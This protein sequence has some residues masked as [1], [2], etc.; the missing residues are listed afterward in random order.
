[1][2]SMRQ[3]PESIGSNVHTQGYSHR[4]NGQFTL[5]AVLTGLFIGFVACSSNVYF[6]LQT[7]YAV[8]VAMP[9][10]LIGFGLSKLRGSPSQ[11]PLSVA[12]NVLISTIA[13]AMSFMPVTGSFVGVIP[14]LEH[15]VTEEE[16]GPVK[17][18][19]LQLL[20]WA[21]GLILFGLVS[22]LPLREYFIV[23][24]RLPFPSATATAILIST[25]HQK[26]ESVNEPSGLGEDN[27]TN[28][29]LEPSESSSILNPTIIPEIS[30]E[31]KNWRTMLN[32]LWVAACGSGLCV[33]TIDHTA[34][35]STNSKL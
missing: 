24:Q 17:L 22:I 31:E 11:H 21:L 15:L 4:N 16:N 7:G 19:T 35:D 32:A 27:D 9:A 10:S 3:Q 6:G 23:Y 18:K 1:V 5:R 8:G 34:S 13:G 29:S 26:A 20:L 12:E 28:S 14:A 2:R 30:P 25:L 33:S